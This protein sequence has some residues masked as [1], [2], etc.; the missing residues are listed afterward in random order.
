MYLTKQAI[1]INTNQKATQTSQTTEYINVTNLTPD[2]R[3]SL[4]IDN[5]NKTGFTTF[6]KHTQDNQTYFIFIYKQAP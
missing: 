5:M 3:R 6:I 2:K 4:F 1:K